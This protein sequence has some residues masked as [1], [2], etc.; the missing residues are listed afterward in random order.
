L[1]K[2]GS[3]NKQAY[4]TDINDS[5]WQVLSVFIN[6]DKTTGRPRKYS[7]REILNAIYYVLNNGIKW[8]AMPHDLP[9]WK[10]VYHYFWSWQ[11]QGQWQSWHT[12]LRE[13]LRLANGRKAQPGAGMLDSQSVKTVDSLGLVLLVVVTA[14]NVQDRDGAKLLLTRFYQSF[15]QSFRLRRIWAD[16]GYQG[17]LVQWT[18]DSCAWVLEIVK[19]KPDTQGFEVLP[20]RW[21]VERTFAWFMRNRR[22]CRDYERRPQSSEA[23]IYIAMIRLM[24]KRLANLT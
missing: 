21:I 17:S 22:L 15:L 11:K 20:K 9:H 2:H 13:Q 24:A 10:T 23:F 6:K 4:P 12:Q 18:H 5:E 8:R 1:G 3:V 7:Y 19:R 14:A 16:A